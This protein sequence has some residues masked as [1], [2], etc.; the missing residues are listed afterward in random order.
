[1]SVSSQHRFLIVGNDYAI[2][3]IIFIVLT[4]A[5][6]SCYNGLSEIMSIYFVKN[7]TCL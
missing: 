3:T 1:M 4:H 7:D 6:K 5:F 2:V